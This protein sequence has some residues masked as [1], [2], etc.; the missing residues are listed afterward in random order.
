[1]FVGAKGSANVVI[2]VTNDGSYYDYETQIHCGYYNGNQYEQTLLG[3]HTD[4]GYIV[5]AEAYEKQG[6]LHLAI[7]LVRGDEIIKTNQINF[8][9]AASPNGTVVLP[10]TETWQSMVEDYLSTLAGVT[11]QEAAGFAG[12]A[13]ESLEAVVETKEAFE[14]YAEEK[15]EEI[16]GLVA[17]PETVTLIYAADGGLDIII[18]EDEE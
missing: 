10:S 12:Q 2:Y 13:Q 7:G 8:V 9:V 16:E 11:L 3:K 17:L 5:P 6:R 1:M 14:T 4:G 18:T 15:V